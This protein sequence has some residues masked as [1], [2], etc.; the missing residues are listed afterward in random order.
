V[1]QENEEG[2]STGRLNRPSINFVFFW[3]K[4]LSAITVIQSALDPL[5]TRKHPLNTFSSIHKMI[6]TLPRSRA[7]CSLAMHQPRINA[8]TTHTTH[9]THT[10][11]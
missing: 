11:Y 1:H 4:I 2:D 3:H 7:N 9:T 6:S 5:A 10:T 8:S